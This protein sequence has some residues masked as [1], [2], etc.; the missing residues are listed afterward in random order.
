MNYPEEITLSLAQQCTEH[1]DKQKNRINF[2]LLG[3][4]LGTICFLYLYSK[5]KGQNMDIP[6]YFLDKLLPNINDSIATYC[7]GLCGFAYAMKLL[8]LLECI[9]FDES[10]FNDIDSSIKASFQTML[11]N[12]NIDFLH[13]AT[14]LLRYLVDTN[15][16]LQNIVLEVDR[17]SDYLFS[18]R[19][20]ESTAKGIYSL[21]FSS[22][23]NH[24]PKKNISLSHGMSSIIIV[25]S[26]L[27]LKF[28]HR[29]DV[30]ELLEGFSNYLYSEVGDPST[31][32]S[33]T[34]MFPSDSG[35]PLRKSRL[36]WCYGDLGV[37]LALNRAGQALENCQYNETALQMFRFDFRRFKYS[38]NYIDD[39]SVCHGVAGILQILRNINLSHSG[40][41]KDY[42]AWSDVL[43]SKVF[44]YRGRS[45][46]LY[47]N[48]PADTFSISFS[49]IDGIS[50]VGLVLLN[51]PDSNFFLNKLMLLS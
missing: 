1:L 13:G 34:P 38:E 19:I 47:Y 31:L 17:F 48:T 7:N 6:N 26:E 35:V 46:F 10:Y 36:A 29:K 32:G 22:F 41:D 15:S 20:C 39:A 23:D 12:D 16:T 43:L 14:G 33:Y 8:K 30:Y 21:D 45:S 2:S 51:T 25:L 9:D 18:N 42:A 40:F 37:A 5:S 49:I 28:P 24:T 50:G 44:D 4:D 3:G 11:D 27:L